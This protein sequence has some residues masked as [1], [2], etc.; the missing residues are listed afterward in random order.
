MSLLLLF[1]SG[2]ST[3]S[4]SSTI[5]ATAT[6]T[7]SGL[8]EGVGSST[9]SATATITGA[10]ETER[11]GAGSISATATITATGGPQH[12][13]SGSIG[14][15]SAIVS[16]G[17]KV[18]VGSATIAAVATITASGFATYPQPGY[19]RLST[20]S[21]YAGVSEAAATMVLWT[22]SPAAEVLDAVPGM[23]LSNR[24]PSVRLSNMK[25]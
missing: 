20:K 1:L 8:K 12:S 7:G 17:E 16:T 14:A 5:D 6:I 15:S 3:P 11:A 25:A 23:G 24:M 21:P 9:V 22:L 2:G 4:G 19:A 10:G 13:G 18:G